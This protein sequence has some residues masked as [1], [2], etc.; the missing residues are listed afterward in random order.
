MGTSIV[1]IAKSM[2]CIYTC[3]TQIKE[4]L[5]LKYLYFAVKTSLTPFLL[6]IAIAYKVPLGQTILPQLGY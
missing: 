1:A 6:K 4:L 5:I 3:K 2:T